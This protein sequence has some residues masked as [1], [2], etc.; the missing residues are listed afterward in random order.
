[1][2][3]GLSKD[4]VKRARQIA[5][6]TKNKIKK[7][8]VR[9]PKGRPRTTVSK[10]I[11]EFEDAGLVVPTAQEVSRIYV[12]IASLKEEELVAMVK[13][14][15]L[16]MMTRIVAR[17]VLSKKGIDILERIIDRAYGKEQRI[18]ITTN[19][20]DLKPDPIVV[21]VVANRAEWEKIA[22]EIPD[23]NEKEGK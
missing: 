2:A 7:G 4:P 10:M 18:D 8:E 9:N 1:M 21:Q 15:E 11:T 5:N 20:K 23:S 19:G 17:N 16:P 13:N 22:A 14:K 6:V 12:C 3:G